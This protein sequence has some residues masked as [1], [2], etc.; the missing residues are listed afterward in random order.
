[1]TDQSVGD[2]AEGDVIPGIGHGADGR[3]DAPRNRRALWISLAAVGALGALSIPV[4]LHFTHRAP[5]E[6]HVPDSLVGLKL[7]KTAEAT[8]TADYLRSAIAAGMNLDTSVGGVYTD[9]VGGAQPDAHSVILVGGT[10]TEGTNAS[11]V[12][13][14]LGL[15]DDA[16]DGVSGLTDEAPGPVG[17]L[18]RCGLATDN[19][20]TQSTDTQMS[21]CAFANKGTVGIAL[22][23]NRSVPDA[24]AL[25]RQIRP[26]L[27]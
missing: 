7:D 9:G 24:A 16:T 23:A 8:S 6:L 22:L 5:A 1:M 15:M 2:R 12:S 19:T 25:M 14:L 13:G 20:A 11:Q 10:T 21:I 3:R 4:A 18:M 27:Q 26:A 17:G